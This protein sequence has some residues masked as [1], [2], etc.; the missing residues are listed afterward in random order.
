MQPEFT[1]PHCGAPIPQD[2]LNA[3][4]HVALCRVCG[5]TTSFAHA[6]LDATVNAVNLDAPPRHVTL[7]TDP[8]GSVQIVYRRVSPVALFF[9]PFTLIWG[10]GSVAGV[11]STFSRGEFNSGASLGAIVFLTITLLLVSLTTFMVFGR[12]VITLAQ[13]HGEV[14]MG[15]G[16]LGWRRRFSYDQQSH[17]SV[18]LTG[19]ESDDELGTCVVVQSGATRL[20]FGAMLPVEVQRFVAAVTR[21]HI[22]GSP[23]RRRS[24]AGPIG[25]SPPEAPNRTPIGSRP[26][27]QPVYTC[28]ECGTQIPLDD[29]NVA[30]DSALCRACGR[31]TS[32]AQA[33]DDATIDAV[34][35]DAPPRHVTL[36]TDPL[37]SVQIVYRRVSPAALLF[38][39]F[40]LIWGGVSVAATYD[41][42]SKGGFDTKSSLGT[43]V[44]LTITILLVSVTTFM[45]CGRWVITL[46]QGH[47]EVFMGVGQLGWRRRFSYDRQTR[48]T[49]EP[50]RIVSTGAPQRGI[51]VRNGS[52]RLAFGTMIGDEPRHL[53]AAAM[54]DHIA[55]V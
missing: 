33:A 7:R 42:F 55:R 41:A 31:T 20:A 37:G 27:V 10:G 22:L 1:C 15:V 43:I 5:Q 11:Y 24:P 46:A 4:K 8:L 48:V 49:I 18:Q 17:V 3:A 16:P 40:T 30:Q 51:T 14:F 21:D 38:V 29:I 6:A 9:V 52:A 12:T 2:D 45:L 53:I 25:A 28:R 32:F 34:N 44:V 54:R 47:G 26:P 19:V 39:P 36:R 50:T 13:G 35:L 23:R